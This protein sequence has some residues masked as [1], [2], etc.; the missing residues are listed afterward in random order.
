MNKYFVDF[1][2]IALVYGKSQIQ[3]RFYEFE[4]CHRAVAEFSIA[5][6]PALPM[7]GAAADGLK[8]W[9]PPPRA[10]PRFPT[11]P[12]SSAGGEGLDRP[13]ADLDDGDDGQDE[14]IADEP[15]DDEVVVL[16]D[17]LEDLLLEADVVGDTAFPVPGAT[18][19][20]AGPP[21]PTPGEQHVGE[22]SASSGV[23]QVQPLPEAPPPE[24]AGGARRAGPRAT[25]AETIHMPGGFIAY[26]PKKGIF[27]ATCEHKGHGNCKLTRSCN[28]GGAASRGGLR[29][30][31]PIAFMAAWLA[32]GESKPTKEAHWERAAFESSLQQRLEMRRLIATSPAGQ[33]LL[34]YERERDAGEP[35]E[36][37]ELTAYFR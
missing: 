19:S 13:V 20:N 16:E 11:M 37:A 10:K 28:A 25:A 33:R 8:I 2:G 29:A 6:L 31:R 18:G 7:Q 5:A 4:E 14:A 35:E 23:V 24:A 34:N 36:P 27:Q 21:P 15:E 32:N 22:A 30:G 1:L 9:P 3:V 17:A 26:Y 12:A